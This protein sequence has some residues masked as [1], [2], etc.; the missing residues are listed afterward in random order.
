MKLNINDRAKFNEL[1][2]TLLERGV[3]KSTVTTLDSAL[4]KGL[5]IRNA[6]DLSL[7]SIPAA[8]TSAISGAVV[9]GSSQPRTR[10]VRTIELTFDP[11]AA[12]ASVSDDT[13]ES[14]FFGY[15]LLVSYTN[16]DHFTTEEAYPIG[17]S[18]IVFVDLDLG[19]IVDGSEVTYRVKAPTGEF[20]PIDVPSATGF[21]AQSSVAVKRSE[22]KN[23][24]LKVGVGAP[25]P[26]NNDA[27]PESYRVKGRVLARS[28]RTKLDGFQIVIM[29][30]GTAE[31]PAEPDFQAV[32]Y[33]TTEE[34]GYFI[35][36]FL[37]FLNPADIEHVTAAMAIVSKDDLR[38]EIP[39]TLA[40]RTRTTAG[41]GDTVTERLSFIPDRLVLVI[42]ADAETPSKDGDCGCS[43]LNFHEKKAFEEFSYQ[44]VVRTTEPAVI[45]DVIEETDEIDLGDIYGEGAR[46]FFVPLNVFRKF[47]EIKGRQLPARLPVLRAAANVD[48]TAA[49]ATRAASLEGAGAPT[50]PVLAAK[51]LTDIDKHLLEGLMV[52]YRAD[53]TV[54]GGDDRPRTNKGRAH[55]TPLNQIN[56]D[57]PT[58]YQAASIAH[59]HLLHF[60][61]Q[62]MP[63]G[64][65]IGDLL[66][67]LPLAPGQKKQI[68]VLDWER[69]E[70]AANSQAVAYEESLNN[71][72]VRDRDVSEVVTATLNESVR[73]TSTAKTAAV[74]FGWGSAIMG[75][76]NGGSYGGLMGISGGTSKASS[77][78]SQT[79]HRDTTASSLQSIRDRTTQAASAVRSQRST[80]IQTVSQGERVE[81]TSES[82]ANYNHCHAITIQY[83]EV[84]RHFVVHNRFVDA[85]ECLFVPLQ[86]ANFDIEKALRWRSAIERCLLRR[87]LLKAFDALERIQNERES[88]SEQYYDSIGY[89][90]QNWAEQAVTFLQ[91][92]LFVEFY[93]F[94]TKDTIDVPL[95]DFFKKFFRI[96]LNDFKDRKL[97]DLELSRIVGPRTIEHLLNALVIETDGGQDLRLDVSLVSPFRQNS[98][99]QITLSSREAI[100][101][102]RAQIRGVKIRFDENKVKADDATNITQFTDQYMKVLV[103]SGALRYRTT[104][105]AGTLFNSRIDNDLFVGTDAIFVPTP[106]TLDELRNPRQEDVDAANALLRHLNENLEYFHKCLWFL[107][108]DERRFMLLDGIVAPGKANGRSVASVVENRIIGVAGNSLIMPV[109]PGNQLDPTIDELADL[110]AR[111][112]V[113]ETDPMRVS[114]PTKGVFAEAVIGKC[115]SC[116]EKDESRFWRWEESPIPDSPNTQID[117]I[118]LASRRADPGNLQPKDFPAPVVNIQNA[119]AV[120]DPTGLQAA[121][122]LVGKGDSFRDL[123]GLSENQKNALAAFQKSLD[124]AQAFGKEAAGLAKAAALMDIIKDA[125]KG[126]TLPND[127]AK[128]KAGKVIDSATPPTPEQRVQRVK[129]ML[130]TLNQAFQDGN[131]DQGQLQALSGQALKGLSEEPAQGPQESSVTG[132]IG[133][134]KENDANVAW[135]TGDG[136]A[137]EV[138]TQFRSSAEVADLS[139]EPQFD[140]LFEN[141]GTGGGG[142]AS[143]PPLA[144]MA[145]EHIL[146]ET[147]DPATLATVQGVV[148]AEPSALVTP[149]YD[150]NAVGTTPDTT[151]QQALTTLIDTTPAYKNARRDFAVSLVDL[152]GSNKFTPKY[153]GH[154]DLTNFYGASVNKICGLLGVYQLLAEANEFLKANPSISA[155]ADLAKEMKDAWTQQGITAKHQPLV[156]QILDVQG[157]SPATAVLRPELLARLNKISDGNQNGSTSIVLL[158]FPYIGTT[159]LAHGLFSPTNQGGL[160]VR[161]AYGDISYRNQR[162]SLPVWSSRENPH[163]RTQTHNVNSVSVA[164]YFTLAAQKRMIDAATSSSVLNHLQAGRCISSAI[165]VSALDPNGDLAAKC[166]IFN[167]FVHDAVHYREPTTLRE[168]VIVILT[169]NFRHPIMKRL[170][171]DLVAMVP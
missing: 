74:G 144:H 142:G 32:A 40:T 86:M 155:I 48:L 21:P 163:P 39:I 85:Q 50:A 1:K 134:A 101:I 156:E 45:A 30:K 92:E 104:N 133:A 49:V 100:S 91:G 42:E 16:S 77:T 14:N 65:S 113:E 78:A 151:L 119:P 124:T 96:D 89:P 46:G 148:R 149:F 170:F 35:T 67:S 3:S 129:D 2:A 122:Q 164:Q 167:G 132:L 153:A 27:D 88:A 25:G 125:Q 137:V 4:A 98:R 75:V 10:D 127:Q 99:L 5:V 68:A 73:G 26:V 52:D 28:G 87:D 150:A 105:F 108:S 47:H 162:F 51:R 111:Y 44:T 141:G 17:D 33:A 140:V 41:G 37:R 107:M 159:M 97:S 168:F 117:P 24:T 63:D 57:K 11:V 76:F 22:L 64:Y 38:A 110:R 169:Q 9:F 69:R 126:G 154:N 94:N 62:W 120:P 146:L 128:D 136:N 115:N 6:E 112:Y 7:L 90:R 59:G 145:F 54:K 138:Q 43:D 13:A 135:R 147:I 31:P 55:L 60:K 84:L 72:L 114:L 131:I 70:S 8:E 56:W 36:S 61:Q 139:T 20:A 79:G 165:D 130:D 158:K 58:V 103:R 166:G 121:L 93:F 71:S 83:F 18:R 106:L 171:N 116:E 80:V 118:S 29:A 152:S 102:P 143:T 109:A 23:T 160:W 157:G 19:D 123:T 161:R 66:Y 53:E 81:A 34:G 12:D 82:I 15:Q 95:I